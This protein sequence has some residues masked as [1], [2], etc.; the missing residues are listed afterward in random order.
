VRGPVAGATLVALALVGIV[1]TAGAQDAVYRT[2]TR[3]Q[4]VTDP[5]LTRGCVPLAVASDDSIRELRNK[6]VGA[7]GNTALLTLS[8]DEPP[9]IR[10]QIFRCPAPIMSPPTPGAPQSPPPPPPPGVPPP[11]PPR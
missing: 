4:L 11:P 2:T 7:G 6:I 1:S 10:A 9:E 3:L 5:A 8:I